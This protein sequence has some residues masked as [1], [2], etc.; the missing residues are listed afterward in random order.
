[1]E[2]KE[3]SGRGAGRPGGARRRDA[4]GR[5]V[6][7]DRLGPPVGERK[8]RRVECAGGG[9][10]GPGRKERRGEEGGLGQERKI[11]RK[12]NFLFFF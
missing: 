9:L 5:E 11:E 2:G 3:V 8:G 12:E 4:G 10:A 6:G 1:M 7:D